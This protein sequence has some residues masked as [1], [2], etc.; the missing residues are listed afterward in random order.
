MNTILL[1]LNL[2]SDVFTSVDYT[3]EVQRLSESVEKSK[4][5]VSSQID[6]CSDDIQDIHLTFYCFAL[7]PTK[8]IKTTNFFLP[9]IKISGVTNKTKKG[10]LD[11]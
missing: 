3:K 4:S 1:R 6:R 10:G 2:L 11:F 7:N 5:A 9:Q 8:N